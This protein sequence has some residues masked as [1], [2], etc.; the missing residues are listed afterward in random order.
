MERAERITIK[1]VLLNHS[2]LGTIIITF[3][4]CILF[5]SQGWGTGSIFLV[6]PAC[7]GFFAFFFDA[8][9]IQ[10]PS[11]NIAGIAMFQHPIGDEGYMHG[12]F[13]AGY[14]IELLLTMAVGYE[15]KLAPDFFAPVFKIFMFL[16]IITTLS[17]LHVAI[18]K[19][20]L[21]ARI[22]LFTKDTSA[23]Q[24][25]IEKDEDLAII[26]RQPSYKKHVLWSPSQQ[27]FERLTLI[28]IMIYLFL[29]MLNIIDMISAFQL[30]VIA[31]PLPGI[32]IEGPAMG[33]LSLSQ[34][35]SLGLSVAFFIIVLRTL[36][37]EI[38]DYNLEHLSDVLVK[39]EP[40][41]AT[42]E[43]IIKFLE[44]IQDFRKA[45]VL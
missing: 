30:N 10:K 7:L 42:R 3:V 36:Y 2:F 16:M 37:T 15:A 23:T 14:M 40:D 8:L 9:A 18:N 20:W 43:H 44:K 24:P 12:V 45:G 17:C 28:N 27:K 33:Y 35:T 32:G 19:A 21:T 39:L 26:A 5:F 13:F 38:Y 1:N 11:M 25:E 22:E 34:M 31:I 41:D 6:I 4:F 29:L